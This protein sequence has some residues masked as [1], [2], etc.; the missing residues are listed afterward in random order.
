VTAGYMWGLPIAIT[1]S[2]HVQV[3]LGDL[4]R[5]PKSAQEH[6]RRFNIAD[7][8]PVPDWRIEQDLH[9]KFASPPESEPLDRL[10]GAIRDCNG[11]AQKYC[12]EMVFAAV[13]GLSADRVKNI[14]VPRSGSLPSFQDEVMSLAILLIE[15]LNPQFFAKAGVEK[16]GSL[17][18]LTT[19]L[20]NATGKSEVDARDVI[21]GLFAIQAVRSKAG[22]AHRGGSSG[23]EALG[24]A[25]IDP[26]DLAAGF[27]R[28]VLGAITSVEELTTILEK[29]APLTLNGS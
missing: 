16:G 18:R 3:W 5:I 13:D 4:G 22:G 2:G 1:K 21:G 28:L 15:H 6:W 29:S 25:E 24:R 10:R 11:A 14:R 8:D 7:D 26:E 12:G 23:L 27:E 19:W 17:E 9:A 20:R